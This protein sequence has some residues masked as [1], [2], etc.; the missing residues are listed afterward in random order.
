MIAYLG[1]DLIKCI[2]IKFKLFW[3]SMG[4]TIEEVSD[5]ALEI[6]HQVQQI[7][8]TFHYT[9]RSETF[10]RC[11]LQ[12]KV[13]L[14]LSIF[15][16]LEVWCNN[17]DVEHYRSDQLL[18]IKNEL[19]SMKSHLF[20]FFQDFYAK[21]YEICNKHIASIKKIVEI[22][23]DIGK[24]IK[25]VN[26]CVYKHLDISEE[27]QISLRRAMREVIKF[28]IYYEKTVI[29][30]LDQDIERID[31][32]LLMTNIVKFKKT[33]EI[34]KNVLKEQHNTYRLCEFNKSSCNILNDILILIKS[35][36][37]NCLNKDDLTNSL[38]ISI[39]DYSKLIRDIYY[40]VDEGKTDLDEESPR[41]HQ[42]KKKVE[43]TKEKKVT[44]KECNQSFPRNK[45]H[46]NPKK[47]NHDDSNDQNIDDSL[48]LI[49]DQ[50]IVVCDVEKL[51][52]N[53][54]YYQKYIMNNVTQLDR[55]SSNK[56]LKSSLINLLT[57]S[58]GSNVNQT[59]KTLRERK[60]INHKR[61]NTD[62][63]LYRSTK[64]EK[65]KL[66]KRLASQSD[67]DMN[68][69]REDTQDKN[70][71][72]YITLPELIE[73]ITDPNSD[74][75]DLI[76]NFLFT[77]RLFVSP[78]TLLELLES[79]WHL[80][81]KGSNSDEN[82]MFSVRLCVYNVIKT[83]VET[84]F[85]DFEEESCMSKLKLIINLMN[86]NGMTSAASNIE[87]LVNMKEKLSR[88][89]SYNFNCSNFPTPIYPLSFGSIRD[90]HPK[91]LARQIS[92]IEYDLYRSIKPYELL[93]ANW[94][95]KDKDKKSP[96]VLKMI[97]FSNHIINWL[98]YEVLIQE[99]C[100]ARAL[101]INRLLF[102]AKYLKEMNNLN[103]A[104]EVFSALRSSSIFR[105]KDTWKL[106][107]KESWKI[108]EDMDSF[109]DS[110]ANYK[111]Y[112]MYISNVSSPCIPYLGRHLSDLLFLDEKYPKIV[113]GKM[114]CSKMEAIGSII[115][116]LISLHHVPYHFIPLDKVIRYIEGA[117]EFDDKEAYERSL[118]L[119]KR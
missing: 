90:F 7:F 95:K 106:I 88:S 40:S 117:K 8:L 68:I 118:Q 41:L 43:T 119:E 92:L 59:D 96:N 35:I 93:E 55:T 54:K 4:L 30:G 84:N 60:R 5:R 65:G 105:L 78:T 82:L 25:S 80:A 56:S 49:T 79:R 24:S 112:R 14:I 51:D 21:N 52:N 12:T 108:F 101:V 102:V 89:G 100:R 48:W 29:N 11:Q 9:D 116:F 42:N 46:N 17:D 85:H 63:V 67:I 87:K 72:I 10:N 109:F 58:K 64:E 50:Y 34:I 71:T 36:K 81:K 73:K 23:V 19:K 70:N 57:K 13:K 94:T 26:N 77:Y 2:K 62:Y 76:Q 114:N 75:K 39:R 44:V 32:D 47:S 113:E 27:Q 104:M 111:N 33:V 61:S 45:T 110:E 107:P 103:G 115:S 6:L 20:D 38:Q 37:S 69:K 74:N 99:N 31:F 83:W 53:C 16:T 97:N 1:L 86:K 3:S 18:L 28:L 22:I 91:E 15:Q 66:K 98:Q